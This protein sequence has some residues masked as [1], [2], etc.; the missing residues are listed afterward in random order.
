MRLSGGLSGIF[1]AALLLAAHSTTAQADSPEVVV[2]IKPLYGLTAAIM[3]GV[4][5]PELLLDETASP[6]GYSLRPSDARDLSQADLVVWIG[7]DLES[8]LIAPLDSLASQAKVV[9][10]QDVTGLRLYPSR[11]GGLWD[12]HDHHHGEAEGHHDEDA[13]HHGDDDAHSHDEDAHHHDDEEDAAEKAHHHEHEDEEAHHHED[14]KHTVDP[15][16]WLD[17]GNAVVLTLAI[18]EAL[19]QIDPANAETYSKNADALVVELEALDVALAGQ[20]DSV[21]ERP[22]IVF[23][24][25]YQYFE[26]R[27]D[28][29]AVGSITVSP[30]QRPGA[31]RISELREVIEARGAVCIFAEPQF[32]SAIL[33]SL[34]EGTQVTT[35]RLDPL[36]ANVP[37]GPDAYQT[38]L[39]QLGES[40]VTCLEAKA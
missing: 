28:L 16:I 8:F 10:G 27:Y 23:H 17:P 20:M 12:E 18:G 4:A 7:P 39:R 37:A 22:F 3:E 6:H 25:A 40:L 38:I 15:H 36:G 31:R 5:T 19:Q 33:D 24:D 29:A 11:E 1:T 2:S 21:H 30:D 34:A 26:G 9:T 32:S 13:H 35:G 14:G